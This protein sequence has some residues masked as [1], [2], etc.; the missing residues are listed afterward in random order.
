MQIYLAMIGKI[1]I[2]TKSLR[3]RPHW[4]VLHKSNL[5][6]NLDQCAIGTLTWI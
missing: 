4:T 3:N 5:N 1:E 6:Y 2:K